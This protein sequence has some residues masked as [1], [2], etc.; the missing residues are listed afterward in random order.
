MPSCEIGKPCYLKN[1]E[2][3]EPTGMCTMRA[4]GRGEECKIN[5]VMRQ[6]GK[7]GLKARMAGKKFNYGSKTGELG[8]RSDVKI[9]RGFHGH[10]SPNGSTITAR[11]ESSLESNDN[12]GGKRRRTRKRKGKKSRRKGK[13]SRRKG[14]QSRRKGRKRR[15]R[16]T[17]KH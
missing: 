13:K 15:R 3:N 9:P 17:K 6:S 7:P 12:V 11:S 8:T 2:E 1:D 16:R 14:K 4:D 10:S 5:Y